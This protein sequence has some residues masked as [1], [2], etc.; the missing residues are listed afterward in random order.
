MTVLLMSLHSFGQNLWTNPITGINP[1][2]ENPY[3]TDQTRDPNIAV[4]G[5]SRGS[6]LT[7]TIGVYSNTFAAKNWTTNNSI[8]LNDYFEFTLTPNACYRINFSQFSFVASKPTLEGPQNFAVRSS[9]DNYTSNIGTVTATGA[10]I[11]LSG[12]AYQ[13]IIS[14]ITFR[15]YGWNNTNSF[16]GVW[17]IDNFSFTGTVSAVVPPTITTSSTPAVVTPVCK[18]TVNQTTTLAYSATTGTPINYS[19]DWNNAANSAGLADQGVTAFAFA[20]GGG[21]VTGI[22]VPSAPPVGTYSGVMTINNGNCTA[23]RTVT[24]T[25]AGANTVTLTSAAGTNNQ[26]RCINTALTNITFATTGATGATI[27]GLP[28]GVSGF[29]AANVFTI[30]GTPNVSGSFPYT[31][32]LTGGCGNVTTSG[33]ITVTAANTVMLTS[34]TGTNNQTRCINTALT[35]ITYGTTGATGGMASGL[36]SGVLGSWNANVFTISGTPNV[37]GSF[38]YMITLT[39]G[40]GN[41]TTSGTITVTAANTVALTSATGTNNQARCINTAL[42]NITFATT[43]ATGATV[44]GL[45]NGVSGSWAANVFTISGTPTVSGSFPYMVTLTGGCGNVTSSGTITVNALPAT[46]T[47]SAGGATTFCAGGSVTL[48]SSVG[49]TYLWSTGAT[50]Q[51]INTNTSGSYTVQ[52]TNANGCQSVSSAVTEITVNQVPVITS[53]PVSQLDCGGRFVNFKVVAS[54]TGLSYTWQYK[55]PLDGS[56]IALNGTE[57]NTTYPSAGEIRIGNVGSAQ[58]PDGTQFQV[59]VAN[60]NCS[61]LSNAVTL[62]VNTITDISPMATNV[63][64][65]Y[66]AN[67][68]YTVTSTYPANVVSYQWK[69]SV[70]SGIWDNVINDGVYSGANTASLTITAGT[71]TESAEYRVYITFNNS[72]TQCSVDSST[73]TRKITF[74]PQLT[75][76][77]ATITQPTCL[78]SSGTITVAVQSATDTYSFDNGANFQSS[79]VKSGLSVG[80]YNL[81]IKNSEGCLSP[82]TNCEIVSETSIW[83]GTWVNGLPYANRGVVFEQDFSSTDDLEACSCQVING[84]NVVINGMHTLKITNA[85]AVVSGSLTFENNA[86]LVQVNESPTINSGSIIY[87]RNT[88]PLNRYDFT[89]WSSPVANMTLGLPLVGLSPETFYDKYFSYNN[90]WVPVPRETVM[91]K[92][93]GYSVRAPQTREISGNPLPFLAIFKGVP[94]NGLVTLASL[95]GN[96]AHLLGNPYPSAI[97]A[98]VFIDLNSSVLEGTLYFWT[99]N[100]PPSSATLGDKKY[101]YTTNDYATYNRTGGVGTGKAAGTDGV[102]KKIPTGNIAAGQGFFAPV[103]VT[104]NVIF[105]NAMR[106]SGGATGTD[107]SQFFKLSS[108]S[109]TAITKTEKNRIWLNLSNDEGAFK[110]T[111]IGY[112]PTTTNNYDSGFDAITYDGNQYVDFYSVNNN[113]NLVI[114]GRALPFKKQDSVTLGYKSTIQG[115]FQISIDHTDGSLGAENIFLEDKELQLFHDLKKE[116]YLFSTEKGVFNSRFVLRYVD[117]NKILDEENF[118]I[119][120]EDLDESVTVSVK[121]RKITINSELT[122]LDNLALYDISGRKIFQKNK[123][124]A[125]LLLI[126]GLISSNQ[127][128]I[129]EIF[130]SNGRK[131]NKKILY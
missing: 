125:K 108:N 72:T 28:N 117:K 115:E 15:V 61:V 89:Y 87:K 5:V 122:T 121:D 39:G 20:A 67:Y 97:D 8:G 47:I 30:S 17:G 70:A 3:T 33:T 1:Q 106:I 23:T 12:T 118:D 4:S 94:H 55:R 96:Q 75:K 85:V 57:T 99:H 18:S 37:S 29:W 21:S 80:F 88:S 95:A 123:I 46:P 26:A 126:P 86:S 109:K 103:K 6:A 71:P 49:T 130:L 50:T 10:T 111:L 16:S 25:I 63:T 124:D 54:G 24:L 73:R 107:N 19:I 45:P 51:S 60:A 35:N 77:E 74:L 119:S 83:N 59:I 131:I 68:T 127:I 113:M 22:L 58:Y 69:K 81:I 84:A 64:L 110:Q 38:P 44:S 62:S 82:V 112:I 27:S 36:P 34:A 93:T 42:T 9:I 79:N 129:V 102:I 120:V 7:T 53:Q 104:G 2:T 116:P 90:T 52:I 13:N 31:V 91:S 43:G 78:I 48:T 32:T 114:Q 56:F 40:C 65:C 14:A 128:V 100:S 92:G 101:N 41:V 11:N 66:G 105:N 76:P 98:D